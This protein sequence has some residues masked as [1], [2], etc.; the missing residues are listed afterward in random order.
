MIVD[1][2]SRC[3]NFTIADITDNRSRTGHVTRKYDC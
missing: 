3:V 1:Q 2:K